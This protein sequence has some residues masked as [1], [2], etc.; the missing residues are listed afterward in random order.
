[1]KKLKKKLIASLICLSGITLQNCASLSYSKTLERIIKQNHNQ[2]LIDRRKEKT[3]KREKIPFDKFN[4][5]IGFGRNRKVNLEVYK[6]RE[7][8]SNIILLPTLG[9]PISSLNNFSSEMAL[10][11]HN[12]FALDIEGFGKS[13]GKR[14][15]IIWPKIKQDISKTIEHIKSKNNKKIILAG[16][17]IGSEYSLLYSIEGKYKNSID[18]VIAHGLYGFNFNIPYSDFRADFC[19]TC[20]GSVLVDLFGGE[21]LDIFNRL[22]KKNFYNNKDK[23]KEII[24]NDPDYAK[25]IDLNSYLDFINYKPKKE[26]SSYNG[27][28]LLIVSK[29][30]KIISFKRSLSVYNF[31]KKQ[32]LNTYLYIPQ[33]K[34]KNNEVP[35]MA[36]DTN[37]KEITKNIDAFLRNIR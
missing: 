28:I 2:I 3:V 15:E 36:F 29:D 20:I 19:K 30:D 27:N 6:S 31:L 25:K 5:I 35:H 9:E 12:I 7:A 11:R 22:G 18:A 23:F 26:L 16:T 32:N 17:S 1:M 21:S 34:N 37:Y 13:S 33:G 8:F 24:E 10:Y 14:G 4:T